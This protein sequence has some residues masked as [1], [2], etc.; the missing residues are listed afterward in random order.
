MKCR[1]NVSSIES[2]REDMTKRS[3]IHA[4]LDLAQGFALIFKNMAAGLNRFK[5]AEIAAAES[6]A[7][8]DCFQDQDYLDAL[9]IAHKLERPDDDSW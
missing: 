8:R 2:Y 3:A 6:K 5:M 4:A 1:P 9:E 7:G